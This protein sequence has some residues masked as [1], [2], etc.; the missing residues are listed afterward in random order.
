MRFV[1]AIILLIIVLLM[2]SEAE[3]R[4]RHWDNWIQVAKC[5]TTG[6]NW[7]SNTG[8]GYYGGL[9]MDQAFWDTARKRF[10]RKA[11]RKYK[12]ADLAPRWLQIAAAETHRRWYGLGAWPHCQRYW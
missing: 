3:A 7:R 8:N 1:I 5:E 11:Y 10:K 4:T 2:A 9:Q 6:P 12:R